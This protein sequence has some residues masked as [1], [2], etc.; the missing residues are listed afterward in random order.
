MTGPR[1]V[2]SAQRLAAKALGVALPET[3]A[4]P[5]TKVEEALRTAASK[6]PRGWSTG[7]APAV[8]KASRAA[9]QARRGENG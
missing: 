4:D 9:V 8:I 5:H 3:E 2:S 6:P 1:P 7:D